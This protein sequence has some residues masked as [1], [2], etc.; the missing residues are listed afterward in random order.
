[1]REA[2]SDAQPE[3]STQMFGESDA[4]AV[5]QAVETFARCL[6]E[7]DFSTWAEYW[8]EDGVLMPPGHPSVIG[9]ARIL[10]F[11]RENFH[12]VRS[13]SLSNWRIDGNGD[14]AV[15]TNDVHWQSDA[16]EG[17]EAAGGAK[18][19]MLLARQGDGKWVRK[20]VIYNSDQPG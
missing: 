15:V 5:R 12:G 18:Q 4:S 8:A 19:F 13:M 2:V 17:K 7:E 20:I 1:M 14:L 16:G 3:V 11:V 9:R 10:A 6:V